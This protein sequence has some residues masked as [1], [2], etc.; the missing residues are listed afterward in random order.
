MYANTLIV[1]MWLPFVAA[2]D[3]AELESIRQQIE[4][5]R[6]E[7]ES[8]IE[9]LEKRLEQADVQARETGAEAERARQ[10]A[11]AAATAIAAAEAATPGTLQEKI[12][13]FNPAITAVLQGSF[14]S[15]SEDPGDYAVSGFQLG[16]ESGLPA[17]GLTLDETELILSA[18]VDQLFYGQTTIAL[19]DDEEETEVEVEEAFIDALA[20]PA[21]A[22]LRLPARR[23]RNRSSTGY[24]A[25]LR[26]W[27]GKLGIISKTVEG[28]EF[29]KK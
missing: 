17:Q 13:A 7:Y 20:L 10:Q 9:A 1:L 11:G 23:S 21:G 16:G 14:N 3:N 29:R 5:L 2:A 22:G 27:L 24:S 18:N 8:R 4:A 26:C 12:N 19:H 28:L 25:S 6:N 15:Y